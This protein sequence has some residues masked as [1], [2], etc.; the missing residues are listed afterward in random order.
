M[1]SRKPAPR[2]TGKTDDGVV[3]FKIDGSHYEIDVANLT[4]GEVEIVEEYFDKPFDA[5]NLESGRGTMIL[6][7]LAR[8]RKNPSASLDELRALDLREI[9]SEQAER[10]TSVPAPA[11]SP[12]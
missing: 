12:S 7:H 10:P 5:V 2:V 1:A 9:A 11:G 6:A 8:L 4:W 3:R